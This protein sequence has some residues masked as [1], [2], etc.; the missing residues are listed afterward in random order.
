[1]RWS[2][3][4]LMPAL[5]HWLAVG[6]LL[7]L[8]A[9]LTTSA[10]VKSPTFD[11]PLHAA[12]SYVILM[13]GGWR[14]Q[15]GHPPLVHRLLGPWFWLLP[16][17]PD[18]RTLPGW[19]PPV[20]TR[21]AREVFIAFDLH[22]DMLIFPL[23]AVVM[24]LTLLLGAI[25][26]RWATEHHG[27]LGGLLALF[28]YIFSPNI[29]AHGRLVTT[30]L[31]LTCF[32]F[33]A[34][35]TF[36]RLLTHPTAG[37]LIAAGLALGLAL[38]TK[39]SALLLLPIFAL[40]ILA[41]SLG[42]SARA[43]L[44][45]FKDW[46]H[47]LASYTGWSVLTGLLALLIV[48]LLYGLEIGPWAKRW[49]ALPLPS[50]VKTLLQVQEHS[51]ARGHPAFLMGQRSGGGWRRYFPIVLAI[52]TPLSILLGTLAGLIWLLW[53][54]RWWALLTGAFPAAFFFAVA[55][56]SSLNI[57]YRHILP[58]VP[59]LA[60]STAAL[61]E[62]CRHHAIAAA[63]G[64][65]LALWL[66]AGTLGIYPDYLAYFNEL[67]GG[68]DEGRHYLTD[69]NLDWGQDIIQLRDYLE[70]HNVERVYMSYFGNIDPATYGIRYE[71]LPSHFSLGKVKGFTPFAPPPGV[72]AISVTNLS[73]QY[74]IENPSVLDWFNHQVPIASIGHTIN[75]YH[76]SADPSPPTRVGICRAPGAPLDDETFAENVKR[77]DLRFVHFDCRSS[78]S[79]AEGGKPEW[80]VVPATEETEGL[81]PPVGSW[82]PTFE[83]ENY[84]GK[85]LFTVYWW[86]RGRS[87]EAHLDTLQMAPSLPARVGDTM[88]LLGYEVDNPQTTADEVVHLTTYWRV[89]AQ[90]D[91]SLSL[92]AH[93]VDGQGQPVAVGDG[94]G[95]PFSE[96]AS[97]DV[98]VQRHQLALE[99]TTSE[100]VYRLQTGAYWLPDVER[101]PAFDKDGEPLHADTIPLTTIKV[102]KP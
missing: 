19:D 66:I 77:N 102:E 36:Q 37:R 90:P 95:V 23:R 76:V 51:G 1:M 28:V 53:Q 42:V 64:G 27:S 92:M 50:Y 55:S 6:L 39:V 100:G 4:G 24:G 98:I 18:P 89:L 44:K 72:Y 101:L 58:V 43:R 85:L 83:R 79:F 93:L 67:V 9:Q 10:A 75:I 7:V 21:L 35:Y 80:F 60:L 16:T 87:L 41:Q 61:A 11:E 15:A 40:L 71:P 74:L 12:R 81:A 68:P 65:G 97:G 70:E 59:F 82:R 3:R 8:F 5:G 91:R 57:G 47:R 38:G 45:G 52:K 99:P 34:V 30:D 26:Y 69:S 78:W 31:A 14:M 2:L 17:R 13:T 96:W 32:F 63:A 56:F 20:H 88:T 73:G 84:G 86:E 25:L 29:L 94:L 62:L 49:P 46:V 48:W 33:L 54:K 22:P